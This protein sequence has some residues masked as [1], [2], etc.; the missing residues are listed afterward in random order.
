MIR[1]GRRTL[2][3]LM[4]LVM[5]LVLLPTVSAQAD[6]EIEI[7]SYA[8]L[9]AFAARVNGGEKTLNAKLTADITCTDKTWTPIGTDNE[10]YK[11]TFNGQ[12][13]T[14]TGLS[15]ADVDYSGLSADDKV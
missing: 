15:N 3:A 14:I 13:H 11:G 12:G 4:A 5:V 9:K 10:S 8:D 6:G 7:A 2:A 1:N